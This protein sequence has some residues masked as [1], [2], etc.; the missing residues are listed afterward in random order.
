MLSLQEA[1]EK[2]PKESFGDFVKLA[3][4]EREKMLQLFPIESW[5]EMPLDKY[6]LGQ[7]NSENTFCRW[8]EF[9]T[10]HLGSIRG[11]S[12]NKLIIYKHKNRPGWYYDA[13]AYKNEQDAWRDVRDSFVKAFEFAKTGDYDDIDDLT[14]LRSGPSLRVKVLYLYFPDQIMPVYTKAHMQHFLSL[15][16]KT[17]TDAEPIR[18][19]RSLLTLLK[20]NP[21]FNNWT[22]IEMMCFL[23]QWADPRESSRIVKVPPGDNAKFWPDCLAGSYVCVGWDEIGDLREFDS[24]DSFKDKF[25]ELYLAGYNN[26]KSTTSKKAN[27]LW[28]LR[29]LEAGDIV[30]ANKGLSKVLAVGEV[31]EPGY[32]WMPEREEYKHIVHVKWDTSFE[33]EIERQGNWGTTTVARVSLALYQQITKNQASQQIRLLQPTG[34]PFLKEIEDAIERKCQV[35]L[36]G[37][38]GTGKTYYARRFSVWWLLKS[39]GSQDPET[40]LA[41]KDAFNMVEK[42]LSTAQMST[43]FWWMVANPQNWNW[44]ELF[45]NGSVEYRYGR[46][47]KNFPKVQPGDLVIGYQASPDKRIVALAKITEGLHSTSTG[48]QKITLAP[49][50]QIKNGL[51]FEELQND[52]VLKNSEPL[53]F[54]NQGTLFALTD[55]ET[56]Y[57]SARLI[58]KDPKIQDILRGEETVGQLTRL[59]FHPSYS[60]EDFIEG[61]RPLDTG[62]GGLALRLEDGI[63]KRVCNEAKANPQKKY[64]ILIDEINRANIAKVFGEIITLLEKDKRDL[65]ITLPQSKDNFSI[66]SN[67][68]LLGTMNTADR[69]I[70]LLDSALRRRFAFIEMMPNVE[71]LR[72]AK[73]G[74][75][76]LDD[77]LDQINSRIL[78]HDGREKQIGHSFLLKDGKPLSE[79][80]ELARCFK[81]E[82]L[83]LLQEYCYDDYATLRKYLGE[84]FF[85]KE[86]QALDMEILDDPDV[87]LGKLEEEF[88]NSDSGD[89]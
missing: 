61:F 39:Q 64:L 55:R 3:E 22:T 10:Q 52:E 19:N 75:L 2:Y 7:E 6:A 5:S 38:P 83:P 54:R 62:S 76:P 87:L 25:Y 40:V 27:E 43:K 80:E 21:A 74:N 86:T 42:G 45:T 35:I 37:P 72:G 20:Q 1:L 51:T 88:V 16:G 12:A 63:F 18:L 32:D 11:G 78:K 36:Y 33:K 47:K 85:N 66:P 67:V 9:N 65:A 28:T 73:I 60:Y 69:S 31:V 41:D 56:E 70:K 48:E 68:F 14:P 8:I 24:K 71:I 26:S 57:L 29:E 34:E 49:V 50:H 89:D 44:G 46:L 15:L 79:P 81:Q 17:D 23:Y 59:T 84:K 4:Q 13:S 30:I 58:E 82:I 53:Q 77:F